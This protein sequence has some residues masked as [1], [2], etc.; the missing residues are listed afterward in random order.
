MFGGEWNFLT[1][2]HEAFHL[3]PGFFGQVLD[4]A[5]HQTVVVVHRALCC[6][7]DLALRRV[8]GTVFVFKPLL[9]G[10]IQTLRKVNDGLLG[11]F[12]RYVFC[13]GRHFLQA[14][15]PRGLLF[16]CFGPGIAQLN[17]AHLRAFGGLGHDRRNVLGADAHGLFGRQRGFLEHGS[18]GVQ[19]LGQLFDPF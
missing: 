10:M 11:A 12:E 15:Y 9:Q 5:T 2:G 18:T 14:F 3:R 17:K 16:Q 19:R 4:E 1:P 7:V 8:E 6:R 13:R